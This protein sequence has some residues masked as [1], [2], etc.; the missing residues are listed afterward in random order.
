[1]EFNDEIEL[2]EDEFD[3]EN[4]PL[5]SPFS[6]GI[7]WLVVLWFDVERQDFFKR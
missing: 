7:K 3:D 5:T 4:E 1:M 6:V 2:V